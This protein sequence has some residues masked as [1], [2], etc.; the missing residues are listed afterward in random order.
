MESGPKRYSVVKCTVVSHPHY[1]LFVRLS[2]GR[3]GY[4]DSDMI[5]DMPVAVDAW[6]PVGSTLRAV[7]LGTR[8]DGVVRL[9]SQPSYLAFVEE[10]LEPRRAAE[11]W[12]SARRADESYVAALDDLLASGDGLAVLRWQLATPGSLPYVG[13]ALRLLAVAPRGVRLE[14]VGELVGLVV[15]GSH[16]YEV[17]AVLGSVGLR[18]LS[19]VLRRVVDA[20]TA[21]GSL[22]AGQYQGLVELL[23]D[24]GA[25]DLVEL[26]IEAMRA[27]AD[28]EL[29]LLA[30]D[31]VSPDG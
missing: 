17:S 28:P 9:C 19:P 6:P 23:R 15:T 22:T 30:A 13:A 10:A 26:T 24:L 4:V 20:L 25:A 21:G 31:L 3:S 7:V 27:S 12:V 8:K 29:L 16:V 2:S 11:L 14:L 18:L 5:A 1:G